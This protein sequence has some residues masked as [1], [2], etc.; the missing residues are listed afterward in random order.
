MRR[1]DLEHI[2][3]AAAVVADVE[4]LIIVGSQSILGAYPNAPQKLLVSQE[5]DIYP[6]Q[7]P[8]RAELIEGALGELSMFHDTFGYYAQAVGPETCVLADGWE[9]RLIPI[10]NQGTR[11]ATG[12][13][14]APV[15]L[16]VAKLSAQ[17]EKDFEFVRISIEEGLVSLADLSS[18]FNNLALEDEKRKVAIGFLAQLSSP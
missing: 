4:E 9:D 10:Q 3:R 11:G 13:C 6:K 15:D 17:R 16:L 8:E 14:L 2:I 7:Y 12:W 1:I 5:A 18:A